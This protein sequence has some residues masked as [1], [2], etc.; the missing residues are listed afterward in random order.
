MHLLFYHYIFVKNILTLPLS[1]TWS[2]LTMTSLSLAMLL[3]ILCVSVHACTARSLSLTKKGTP[4]KEL[5][6]ANSLETNQ[7]QQQKVGNDEIKTCESCSSVSTI[8]KEVNQVIIGESS[9]TSFQTDS[10]SFL[11]PKDE[12]RHARSMLGPAQHHLEE[13]V[14]TNASDTTEDIVEMDYAQP[15]RKPPIHNEKH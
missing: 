8:S 13:T 1:L 3:L 10:P 14:I 11:A 12:R 15:H 7:S 5:D 4:H 9:G 2:H 6:N